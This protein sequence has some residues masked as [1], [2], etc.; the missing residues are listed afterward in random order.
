MLHINTRNRRNRSENVLYIHLGVV[1]LSQRESEMCRIILSYDDP[2]L[3]IVCRP[4]HDAN[5]MPLL[6]INLLQ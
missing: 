3:L 5:S 4:N 1:L 2:L 6:Q